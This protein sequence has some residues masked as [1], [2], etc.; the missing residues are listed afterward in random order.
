MLRAEQHLFPT[1]KPLLSTLLI[2]LYVLSFLSLMNLL[3]SHPEDLLHSTDKH[4]YT[5]NVRLVCIPDK[6]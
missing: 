5:F 6:V 2:G 3:H 1:M 4:I